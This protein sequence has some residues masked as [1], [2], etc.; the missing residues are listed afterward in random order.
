MW[1]DDEDNNPY[2]SFNPDSTNPV[3][4]TSCEP[5][6][7]G[8]ACLSLELIVPKTMTNKRVHLHR[9]PQKMSR[10]N[11]YRIQET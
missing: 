7:I 11:F 9:N 5:P 3:L 10:R 4:D 2:G 1:Q 6:S 8:S